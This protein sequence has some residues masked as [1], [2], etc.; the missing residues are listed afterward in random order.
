MLISVAIV[1][2]S[3][4]L[5]APLMGSAAHELDDLRHAVDSVVSGAVSDLVAASADSLNAELTAS[6]STGMGPAQLVIV[7]PG[8]PE[9]FNAA[10]PVSFGSFGRDFVV[11][12]L[13]EGSADD[14]GNKGNAVRSPN[15]DDR[16]GGAGANR[17]L[18]TPLMVARHLASRDV[19]THPEHADLWASAR[20]ITTSGPDATSLGN[21]LRD[22]GEPVAMILIADGATCHGPKAPR[23]EDSRAPAYEDAVCEA[24]ASGQPGQLARSDAELGRELGAT[25]PQVWPVLL[26]AAEGNWTG[27]LVW[28]GSQLGVGWAVAAWRRPSAKGAAADA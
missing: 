7:G 17:E 21:M 23:A 12:A 9:E 25:G 5:V 18:P 20:W 27:E 19:A 3:P 15:S 6:R 1:P 22:V 2:G 16:S 8:P 11:P 4:A 26:A 24:L 14:R 28:R 10:G 13:L